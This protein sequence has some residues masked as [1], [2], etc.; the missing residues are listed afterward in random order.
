MS[1]QDPFHGLV[2]SHKVALGAST[3][4]NA[5]FQPVIASPVV[6]PEPY[7]GKVQDCNRFLLQC[8][9]NGHWNWHLLQC[10]FE[11]HWSRNRQIGITRLPV[12]EKAEKAGS[13]S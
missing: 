3:S 9:S 2:D 10:S 6:N 12:A 8:L 13:G 4:P 1:T 5:P 7:S 11:G